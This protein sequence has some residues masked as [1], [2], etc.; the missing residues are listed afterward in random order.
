M[1]HIVQPS[2]RRP[3]LSLRVIAGLSLFAAGAAAQTP[4]APDVKEPPPSLQAALGKALF[5]DTTLST[6]EGQGCSSCHA[7][8][9]GFR[10]PDSTVNQQFGVTTGVIPGRFTSRSAPTVS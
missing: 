10:F 6:P 3:L 9:A 2:S 8:A 5:F 7:P 4:A 1:S